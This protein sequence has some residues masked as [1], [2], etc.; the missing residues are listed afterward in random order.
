MSLKGILRNKF[1]NGNIRISFTK[2]QMAEETE[3][4]TNKKRKKNIQQTRADVGNKNIHR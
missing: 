1:F 2:L 3:L 4:Q